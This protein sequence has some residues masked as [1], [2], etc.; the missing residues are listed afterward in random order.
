MRLSGTKKMST[1]EY[2]ELSGRSTVVEYCVGIVT[3]I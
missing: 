1:L 3:T 2:M